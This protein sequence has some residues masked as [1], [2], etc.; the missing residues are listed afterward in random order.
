MEETRAADTALPENPGAAAHPEKSRFTI[1]WPSLLVGAIFMATHLA[2]QVFSITGNLEDL[3]GF[4][5]TF[6][7]ITRVQPY[8]VFFNLSF[9]HIRQIPVQP[10]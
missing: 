4:L 3:T 5:N 8:A 7:F 6:H 2:F 10:W 1:G 9:N